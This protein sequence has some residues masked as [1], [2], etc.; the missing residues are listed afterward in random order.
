MKL[1]GRVAIVTGASR[2]IGR[3]IAIELARHGADITINFNS[4]EEEAKEVAKEIESLG[5]R[6][7]PFCA[8]VS[9]RERDRQMVEETVRVLGR[10]DILVNNAARGIRKPFLDLEVA[11]VEKTWGV[12]LWGVFHCSQFAARQMVRQGGGAIVVISSVHA[13]RPYPNSTAYNGAKA[14]I[15]Q[16]AYTWAVELAR[17]NIRVNVI[18]PGWIDTP[19]ERAIFSED[20]IKERGE[21]LLMG[22]LGTSEEIAR[23]VVFLVSEEDSS[24]VTGTCLRIDG[25]FVLP[26]NPSG[27]RVQ[28]PK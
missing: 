15:N 16:M 22:R 21:K 19:G 5:R 12:S 27:K 14:A 9:D 18:E 24:Y 1:A 8:D 25:G 23:G 11:D 3:A 20:Q 13:S 26:E 4:H 10:V 7:L 17:Y 6:A 2:G 28:D